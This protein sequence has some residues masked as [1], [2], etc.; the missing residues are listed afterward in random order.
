MSAIADLRVAYHT[1]LCS[2]TLGLRAG[3]INIADKK[4]I[5]SLAIAD[6]IVSEL[7]QPIGPVSLQG[8]ALGTKFTEHTRRF[9]ES[10]FN[11]LSQ[12]R[13]GSWV[14][15]T[16]QD[17]AGIAAYDQYRH[18]LRVREFLN[19]D[20]ELRAALG[21][22][23]IVIPD[24]HVGR[25]PLS[26]V[27][28]NGVDPVCDSKEPLAKLSPL[29]EANISE[30]S[31]ILHASISCKWTMRSD[32]AQNTRTEALNLMRHRKGRAP[33]IVAVTAEPLPSRLASLARGTGDV[34]FAYHAFLPELLAA[35]EDLAIPDQRNVL[36]EM[37]NGRRL[38]DISDLPLDLA[39]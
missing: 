14:F 9:L 35:V 20:P 19:E 21:G 39:T 28:L 12:I 17:A 38:R 25:R 18:L 30:P 32:R 23:Y 26:E 1:A 29:R 2:D 37:V 11:K 10:S 16:S 24:I 3:V 4:N 13:P 5:T 6:K 34:D 33:H 8:S 36:L 31:L 22:D 7:N 15:S 27:E